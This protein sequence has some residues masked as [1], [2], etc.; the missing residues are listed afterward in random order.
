MQ[1]EGKFSIYILMLTNLKMHT[2]QTIFSVFFY[3]L[4]FIFGLF[5]GV[6]STFKVHKAQISF[7]VKKIN[8]KNNNDKLRTNNN[9][10]DDKYRFNIQDIFF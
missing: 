3:F 2:L 1:K 4:L 6:H 9:N 7:C 5:G 10:Y 8:I